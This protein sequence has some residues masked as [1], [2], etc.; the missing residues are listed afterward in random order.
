[1]SLAQGLIQKEMAKLDSQIEV[2]SK[3]IITCFDGLNEGLPESLSEA[4]AKQKTKDSDNCFKGYIK[5]SMEEICGDELRLKASSQKDID[6]N[7]NYQLEKE[8]VQLK[9][10]RQILAVGDSILG[11]SVAYF[12]KQ[13]EAVSV[14]PSSKEKAYDKTVTGAKWGAGLGAAAG[15]ALAAAHMTG[16]GWANVIPLNAVVGTAIYAAIGLTAGTVLGVAAA[17]TG[18]VVGVAWAKQEGDRLKTAK[19]KSSGYYRSFHQETRSL[20]YL[21]LSPYKP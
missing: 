18:G 3:Q 14:S 6:L 21:S 1:M 8:F 7:P 9:K 17:F 12:N 11:F 16:A 4:E 19:R 20:H 15:V 5:K 10:E 13:G 2:A